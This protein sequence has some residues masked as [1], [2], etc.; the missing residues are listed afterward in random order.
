MKAMRGKKGSLTIEASI[1]YPIFLM[2]IVTMLYII[3]IVYTYGL[4]QHAVSQTAKELSMYTYIYQVTGLN[5]TNQDI[6]GSV[7][8]RTEQFN[9]DVGSVVSLYDSF[10]SGDFSGSYEGTT[11]PTEILKNIGSAMLGEGSAE[12]NN[13]LFEAVVRPMM[14][15]YIGA[16]SKGNSADN[17][18]KALR[19]IGGLKGLDLS[20]SSFF[21]D[22]TTVDIVVCYTIDPLFPID[23]MPEMNMVNRACVRG[24]SGKTVFERNRGETE[25]EKSIWDLSN[26]MSRGKEIQKQEQVRNLPETFPT[27]SAFDPSA[28]TATAVMTI[29]L[30]EDSYQDVSGIRNR[31]RGKCNKVENYKTKTLSGVTV[32]EEDISQKV[33]IIYIPS[34]TKERSID[35]SKYDQAL[36][37]IRKSYPDIQ[38]ETREID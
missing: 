20:S 1:S 38:I 7:S 35:R 21:E 4:V 3:R 24:M 13:W 36:T 12:L 17:R 33:L 37:E 28:G 26:D 2:V 31:I 29:D 30:R 6:Q 9:Q 18:L 5:E 14:E 10:R 25:K 19:V 8:G 27:F 16:D 22:G 32:K 15:G 11:D 23:I 34:S